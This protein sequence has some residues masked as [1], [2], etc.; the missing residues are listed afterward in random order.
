M[1]E[2]FPVLAVL[3]GCGIF[4]NKSR[5]RVNLFPGIGIYLLFLTGGTEVGIYNMI[6]KKY[7]PKQVLKDMVYV[8]FPLLFWLLGKNMALT[9]EAGITNLFVAGIVVSGYDFASSLLQIFQNGDAEMTLYQF[10]H[11]G[12]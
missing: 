9:K 2:M 1:E 8:L 6:M 10:R 12:V 5:F 3:L 11:M 4:M 7:E